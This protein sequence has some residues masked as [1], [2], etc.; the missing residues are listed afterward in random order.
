MK[1]KKT[2]G[3]TAAQWETRRRNRFAKLKPKERARRTRRSRSGKDK[4]R[5]GE[6]EWIARLASHGFSAT[7]R[8]LSGAHTRSGPG[9]VKVDRRG[10]LT[11]HAWE[12]KRRKV[13][14]AW[15]FEWNRHRGVFGGAF[16]SD[17]SS[18]E[19]YVILRA[20]TALMLLEALATSEA[21][22]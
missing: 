15:L 16:R 12:V 8:L 10:R 6:H 5:T 11:E 4:G 14:P 17:G 20:S 9:D 19:W 7:R 3:L 13:M 2:S 18:K 1:T 22:S 21:K